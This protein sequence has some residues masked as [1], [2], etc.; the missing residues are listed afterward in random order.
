MPL[1]ISLLLSVPLSAAVVLA[2]AGPPALDPGSYQSMGWILVGLASITATVNQFMNA[3]LN[4]RKMRE[5][6]A[7]ALCPLEC[8]KL[9]V[10]EAEIRAVEMRLEKRISEQ[11]GSIN[12]RLGTLE[13][14]ISRA[15]GDI[16]YAIGKIDGQGAK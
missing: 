5:P 4:W 14:S 15:I 16:N 2:E 9:R 6:A 7:A 10:L 11:L 1:L 8:A 12:T 3:V 13:T